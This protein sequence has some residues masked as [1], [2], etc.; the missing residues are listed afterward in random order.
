M[1]FF[2]L[3]LPVVPDIVPLAEKTVPKT[4]STT[5]PTTS[6]TLPVTESPIS[7]LPTIETI[8]P[9][10]LKPKGIIYSN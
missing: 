2:Y 5:Q 8:S 1:L 10:I 7:E 6:T 9:K 4:S 3:I